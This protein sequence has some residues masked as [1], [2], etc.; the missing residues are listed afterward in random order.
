VLDDEV[1]IG[2]WL[3][4]QSKFLL[5]QIDG[6]DIVDASGK[7]AMEFRPLMLTCTIETTV[8]SQRRRPSMSLTKA[9]SL[10]RVSV[11]VENW[12]GVVQNL[13]LASVLD[14]H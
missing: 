4:H 7:D 6:Y 8:R 3:A 14:G 5:E 9:I 13:V 11:G 12:V 2:I 10:V 1:R